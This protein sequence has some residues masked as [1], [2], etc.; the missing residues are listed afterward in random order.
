[1]PTKLKAKS[2]EE[3][4]TGKSKIL[5]Y[6]AS[7]V[8]K[9]WFSLTFPLPYYIDCEQ[10][11]DLN[12]YKDRLKAAGGAYLGVEEGSLDFPTV[13][14]QMQA[15]ATEKHG[16]KTLIID[17][18]TKLYQ[19]SIA[20]ESEKLGSKDVFGASKKPAIANM[21]RLVNWSTKLD[22]NI[23]F[24]AHETT[25]WGLDPSTGQRQEVGKIPDIWDKLIYELHLTIKAE[26]R[27]A[28]RVAIIRKSRL[29]GFPEGESFALDY[30]EFSTRYGKDF[31]ES[32]VESIKLATED[33]VKEVLRLL[34][35]VKVDPEKIEKGFSKARVDSWREMTDTQITVWLDYLN[36]AINPKAKKD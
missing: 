28:S 9:T 36:N 26:K 6:G 7:G 23:L 4:K 14:E 11:A 18:I 22:M 34:E 20:N 17:S 31:I 30:P 5:I 29:T 16:Y 10:G 2:P 35:I 19:T 15:L 25:E 24:V 32:K 27:G 1:M 8:G 33:Q 3:T 21:R 12:H 13:I